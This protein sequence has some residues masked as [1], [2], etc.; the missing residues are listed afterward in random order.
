MVMICDS[1]QIQFLKNYTLILWQVLYSNANINKKDNEINS[2][3]IHKIL[4]LT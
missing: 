3:F 1:H 4:L 2:I